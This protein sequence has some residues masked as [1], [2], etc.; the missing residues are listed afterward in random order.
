MGENLAELGQTIRMFREPLSSFRKLFSTM[1]K[2]RN[3]KL[4]RVANSSSNWI[5]A[6]A[7][8]WLEYSF[9]L[10]P[11]V[12]D[13]SKVMGMYAE[14]AKLSAILWRVAKGHAKASMTGTNTGTATQYGESI[15]TGMVSDVE[16]SVTIDIS[17]GT[18]VYYLLP[19]TSDASFYS[20]HLGL[21]MNSLP[22]TAWNLIPHSWIVDQIVGVGDWIKAATPDPDLIVIGKFMTTAERKTDTTRVNHRI[23]T[24][25]FNGTPQWYGG[26]GGTE[27]VVTSNVT[28]VLDFDLPSNPIW[29]PQLGFISQALNDAAAGVQIIS[30][31]LSRW[32]H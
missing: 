7:D 22:V 19:V 21:G 3:R 30:N 23:R 16:R 9:G 2:S 14:K 13:V 4:S 27:T 25:D 26:G 17:V 1:E 24:P 20:R 8:T 6:T 31:L 11:I 5:R 12:E 28:R 15:L 18:G 10:R 32:R 29:N